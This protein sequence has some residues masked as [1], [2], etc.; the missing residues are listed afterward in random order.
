VPPDL[1]P[2]LVQAALAA[3]DGVES[4]EALGDGAYLVAAAHG[5]NPRPDIAELVVGRGWPL[6]ELTPVKLTLEDIFLQ[7]T[8]D[9]AAAV[10]EP[11][12]EEQEEEE[13]DRE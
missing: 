12:V 4:V 5:G 10:E 13:D 7:L 1:Q 8:G 3:V 2:E 11:D 9:E 6:F